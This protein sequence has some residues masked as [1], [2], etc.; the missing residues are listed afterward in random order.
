MQSGW[1]P[2]RLKPDTTK[3]AT[4]VIDDSRVLGRIRKLLLMLL[5]AGSAATGVELLLLGHFE[6]FTQLVPLVLL[7]AGLAAAAWHLAS[8]DASVAALRGLMLAFVLSGGLGIALHYQGNVEFELEMYPALAGTELIGK[9]LTGA[10]PVF[11]PGTMAL[12]GA[13]GLTASYGLRK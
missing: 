3:E 6:E 12:L 5:A 4:F 10:T 7:A 1:I 2:V 8:A 9:T 13:V 11:A